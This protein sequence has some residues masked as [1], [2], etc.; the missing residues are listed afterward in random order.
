MKGILTDNKIASAKLNEI[1]NITLEAYSDS[2]ATGV[3]FMQIIPALVLGVEASAY[4]G[5]P[6][7]FIGGVMLMIPGAITLLVFDSASPDPPSWSK[8]FGLEEIKKLKIYA[9]MPNGINKEQLSELLA[10]NKQ[11]ELFVLK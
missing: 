6:S 10:L 1:E 4:T 7:C 5:S 9:R 2:W 8:D 3:L 11:T